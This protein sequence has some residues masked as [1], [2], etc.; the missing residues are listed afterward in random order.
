MDSILLQFTDGFFNDNL[1]ATIGQSCLNA[2]TRDPHRDQHITRKSYA[3]PSTQKID[4]KMHMS[5]NILP[6]SPQRH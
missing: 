3:Y 4:D 5:K 1:Q 2:F 6:G